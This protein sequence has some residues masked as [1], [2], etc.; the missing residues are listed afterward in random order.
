M[1]FFVREEILVVGVEKLA[2][3][4]RVGVTHDEVAHVAEDLRHADGFLRVVPVAEPPAAH[5]GGVEAITVSSW[6]FSFFFV[7]GFE[8]GGQR[9][10]NGIGKRELARAT[11]GLLFIRNER[12]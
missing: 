7:P 3:D 5:D 6:C 11:L 2:S 8:G 4:V 9:K 12:R 1:S 10:K